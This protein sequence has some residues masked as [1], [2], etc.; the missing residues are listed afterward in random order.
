MIDLHS[1]HDSVEVVKKW[2]QEEEYKITSI[3]N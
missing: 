2:L 3:P 1:K